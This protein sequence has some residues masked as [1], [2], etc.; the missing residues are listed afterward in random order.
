MMDETVPF[1]MDQIKKNALSTLLVAEAFFG[2]INENRVFDQSN[3]SRQR[4]SME[5]SRTPF[6]SYN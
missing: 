3:L 1:C 2:S 4:L 6:D 5:H